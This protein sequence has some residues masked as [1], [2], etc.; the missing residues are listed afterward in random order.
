VIVAVLRVQLVLTLQVLHA[1]LGHSEARSLQLALEQ[2]ADLA[3][4]AAAWAQAQGTP[5][6]G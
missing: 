5:P 6:R 1:Q 4:T 2:A 3:R